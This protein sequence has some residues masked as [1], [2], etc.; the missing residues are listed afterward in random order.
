MVDRAAAGTKDRT[1]Y[2]CDSGDVVVSRA[3]LLN[4]ESWLN[5][6]PCRNLDFA[7]S[8]RRILA[9]VGARFLLPAGNHRARPN[10]G[11]PYRRGMGR[12][13]VVGDHFSDVTTP[14]SFLPSFLPSLQLFLLLSAGIRRPVIDEWF[15]LVYWIPRYHD[16]SVLRRKRRWHNSSALRNLRGRQDKQGNYCPAV[17]SS[18]KSVIMGSLCACQK[19][20]S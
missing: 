18:R 11:S 4:N 12:S 5:R 10:S 19:D 13:C 17:S 16:Q 7:L 9:R 2:R 1:T 3:A 6:T 20:S 8:S 14:R 15:S